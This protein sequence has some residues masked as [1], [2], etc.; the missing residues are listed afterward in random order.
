MAMQ[1]DIVAFDM[2]PDESVA[3]TLGVLLVYLMP[4]YLPP[5]VVVCFACDKCIPYSDIQSHDATPKHKHNM[6][7]H[8]YRIPKCPEDAQKW[9]QPILDRAIQKTTN[10]ILLSNPGM[11]DN[12]LSQAI[13][14]EAHIKPRRRPH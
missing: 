9:G 14:H 3:P 1:E 4:N 10:E 5:S 11:D 13:L 7:K 2:R 6:V 8:A 12:D